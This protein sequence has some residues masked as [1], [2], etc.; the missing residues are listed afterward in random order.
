MPSAA[1]Q[2]DGQAD[3]LLRLSERNETLIRLP[4]APPAE[5]CRCHSPVT[6]STLIDVGAE[7]AEA[8][9]GERPGHGD[10]AVENAVAFEDVA[11]VV[12]SHMG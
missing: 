6:G 5:T 2:V 4:V 9:G 1:L 10:G 8:L 11:A 7:V 12:V 3:R